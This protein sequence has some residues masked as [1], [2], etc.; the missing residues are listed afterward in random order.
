MAYE[1]LERYRK[2]YVDYKTVLQID[3][4]VQAA[5]DSVNRY[6]VHLSPQLTDSLTFGISKASI[7]FY[8]THVYGSAFLIYFQQGGHRLSLAVTAKEI[9]RQMRHG[10]FLTLSTCCIFQI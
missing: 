10:D 2:A 1:S 9:K 6:N 7:E 8:S 5:H 3:V 4:S